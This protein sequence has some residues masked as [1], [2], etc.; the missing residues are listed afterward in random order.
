MSAT[1][2]QRNIMLHAILAVG[3]LDRDNTIT[4]DEFKAIM[5]AQL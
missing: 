5:Q 2:A 3:D 4:F 1:L